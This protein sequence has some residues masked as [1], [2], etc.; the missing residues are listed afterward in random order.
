MTNVPENS[1]LLPVQKQ[2][3]GNV[4]PVWVL[5]LRC[6]FRYNIDKHDYDV[7][8]RAAHR[9]L[10]SGDKVPLQPLVLSLHDNHCE[11]CLDQVAYSFRYVAAG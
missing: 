7:R 8:L 2:S 4:G 1:I 5:T 11:D 6:E 3:N 10:K 9:F